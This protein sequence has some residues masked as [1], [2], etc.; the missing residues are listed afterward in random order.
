VIT[1]EDGTTIKA[2][3]VGREFSKPKLEQRF[4]PFQSTP[5]QKAAQK[6]HRRYE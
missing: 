4:G 2:S 1:A 6:P 3:S 5:E